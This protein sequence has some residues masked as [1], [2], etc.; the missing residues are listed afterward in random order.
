M[1]RSH[2]MKENRGSILRITLGTVM[3]LFAGISAL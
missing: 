2:E 3:I 1:E